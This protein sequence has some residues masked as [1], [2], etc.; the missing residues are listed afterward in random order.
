[1]SFR[2]ALVDYFYNN[3]P[4]HALRNIVFGHS[5]QE[6]IY[7]RVP[8]NDPKLLLG[9]LTFVGGIIL[10]LVINKYTYKSHK[11]EYQIG[12]LLCRL[13]PTVILFM[14]IFP[15]LAILYY[16]GL[17]AH[18]SALTIKV[19][20]LD[21]DSYIKPLDQLKLGEP[22]LLEVDNRCVVPVNTNIRFCVT[23]ADV[24]HSW[25][26]PNFGIKLDA[27]AGVLS[28]VNYNFPM[29]GVFYGQCREICGANHRFIPIALEV[30]TPECFID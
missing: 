12:E 6:N 11:V 21:F 29:V 19:T 28:T 10:Y 17:M 26:L 24:I 25:A 16:Y 15:S 2:I 3:S 18:D 22:R 4:E 1:M 8:N 30:T 20:G 23:S 14:Q 7:F 27:M 5:Y 9:V 13:I